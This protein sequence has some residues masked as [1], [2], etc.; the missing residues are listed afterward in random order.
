MSEYDNI[1]RVYALKCDEG[2]TITVN[3]LIVHVDVLKIVVLSIYGKLV[4][5]YGAH[6]TKSVE[7]E[8]KLGGHARNSGKHHCCERAHA[9]TS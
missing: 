5:N 7:H 8:H 4:H 2:V 1:S 3:V 9:A 6:I